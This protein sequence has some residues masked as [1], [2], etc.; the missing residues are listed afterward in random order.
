MPEPPV[1]SMVRVYSTTL[2]HW[3]AT[4]RLVV[5]MFSVAAAVVT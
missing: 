2:P 4:V 1:C 3:S 5:E